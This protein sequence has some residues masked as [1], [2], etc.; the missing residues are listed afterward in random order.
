MCISS[1]AFDQLL[2]AETESGLLISSI[3]ELDFGGGPL[4]LTAGVLA[5]FLPA[6]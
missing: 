2:K 4:P 3:T 1:S 5:V 6:F